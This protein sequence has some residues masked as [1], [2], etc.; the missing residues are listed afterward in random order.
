[1]IPKEERTLKDNHRIVES[2]QQNMFLEKYINKLS[3]LH[4]L[5]L[6]T[7]SKLKTYKPME[8]IFE[9]LSPS[10]DVFLILKGKVVIVNTRKKIYTE[11]ILDQYGI[12]TLGPKSSLGE[13]GVLY[14]S[15]RTAGAIASTECSC[16]VIKGANF[17]AIVGGVFLEENR[18]NVEIISNCPL[19]QLFNRSTISS[20]WSF[21]KVVHFLNNDIIYKEN[22]PSTSIYIILNG[23]IELHQTPFEPNTG[24]PLLN[25]KHNS[26]KRLVRLTRKDYFGDEN[27]FE[28]ST[29]SC[30]AVVMSPIAE[31]FVI[32]KKVFQLRLRTRK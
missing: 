27:G 15:N 7:F 5:N 21:G 8:P 18:L 22:D 2:L 4:W 14:N 19:L 16:I 24:H 29:N 3:D 30:F 23:E 6:S 31:V 13:T 11:E 25:F 28:A 32:P 1:M 9:A 20:L 12:I 26:T 10:I 17:R